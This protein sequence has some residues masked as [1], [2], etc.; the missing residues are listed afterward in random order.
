MGRT[1]TRREVQLERETTL[2]ELANAYQRRDLAAFG[3]AVR[4]DMT[5][6][7]AGS[8]RLAGTYHGY[9]A[10]GRYL[11]VLRTVL[12]S[13]GEQIQFEHDGNVMVFRQVMV[14]M[15]PAHESEMTLVVTVRYDESD[16]RIESFLVEPEDQGLF[17]H[18]V[19][20]SVQVPDAP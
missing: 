7:W 4:P 9:D 10:F 13:A 20:T 18:V 16:G 2:V 3:A 1:R 15:G 17:D 5:L 12:R 8:S 14:V 6:T 19:N 11:E